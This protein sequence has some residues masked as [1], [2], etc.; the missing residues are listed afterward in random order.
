MIRNIWKTLRFSLV[1]SAAIALFWSVWYFLRGS[2]PTVDSIMLYHGKNFQLPVNISRWDDI[3]IGPIW[4]ALLILL[5]SVENVD[6]NEA[7]RLIFNGLIYGWFLS[8]F[9]PNDPISIWILITLAVAINTSGL[10][11]RL[12]LG[13]SVGL[14]LALTLGIPYGIIFDFSII[15]G[16]SLLSLTI[17]LFSPTQVKGFI[18]WLIGDKKS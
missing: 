14:G 5:L 13:I 11:Y 8:W 4:S 9:I 15:F 18:N 12:I 3:L 1:S 16:V 6:K 10:I 17:W 7:K 2:V